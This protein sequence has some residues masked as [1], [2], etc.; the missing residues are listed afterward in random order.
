MPFP[1]PGPPSTN[2]TVGFFSAAGPSDEDE[3]EED[4]DA[5][6]VVVVVV[7]VVVDDVSVFFPSSPLGASEAEADVVVVEDDDVSVVDDAGL[8]V[9]PGVT[10]GSDLRA[11]GGVFM[12]DCDG[13]V[14]V[15]GGSRSDP[16]SASGC[17]SS[18][19]PEIKKKNKKKK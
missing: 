18:I 9:R 5:I 13:V 19:T 11:E 10:L 17:V 4:D 7:V 1:A 2:T 15:R 6:T 8:G 14:G 16:R 3:E 12:A